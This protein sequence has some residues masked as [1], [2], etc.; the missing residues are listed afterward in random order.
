M[1]R[2][3]QSCPAARHSAARGGGGLTEL[4]TYKLSAARSGKG[5]TRGNAPSLRVRART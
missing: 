3:P 4:F 5:P 1:D 2:R